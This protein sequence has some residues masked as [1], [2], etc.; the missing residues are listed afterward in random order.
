MADKLTGSTGADTSVFAQSIG[1]NMVYRY[2]PAPDKIN[3]IGFSSFAAVL[4]ELSSDAYGNALLTLGG[5]M[6]ITS[7]GVPASGLGAE[8]FLWSTVP[9]TADSG[10]MELS[11]GGILPLS[12][13]INNSAGAALDAWRHPPR[14]K[15]PPL[16]SSHEGGG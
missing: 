1:R 10:T 13:V 11:Y 7:D 14:Q 9:V 5:G 2:D 16:S 3:L 15:Y 4:A 8:D 12:G 6:S